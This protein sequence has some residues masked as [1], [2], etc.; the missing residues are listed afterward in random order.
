MKN[1]ARRRMR[2]SVDSRHGS[3]AL[4]QTARTPRGASSVHPEA[5][6]AA[7]R[8]RILPGSPTTQ[9]PRNVT[10]ARDS[11][12]GAVV[13]K[14]GAGVPV[15]RTTL[16]AGLANGANGGYPAP[17]G[18]RMSG[19][20]PSRIQDTQTS[21]GTGSTTE[22]VTPN[23]RRF[24]RRVH[25]TCVTRPGSMRTEDGGDHQGWLRLAQQ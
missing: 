23:T 4:K 8:R 3:A 12:Q 19:E 5:A 14:P 25:S 15:R 2:P 1:R 10:K 11:D 6:S 7:K 17:R 9:V 16:I 20:R 18:V 21:R 24:G 13:G 22:L